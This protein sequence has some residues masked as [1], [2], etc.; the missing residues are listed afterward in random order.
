MSR[1][2]LI[3]AM[4]K[5]KAD[6]V[7]KTI[8]AVKTRCSRV[9]YSDMATG[10][11]RETFTIRGKDLDEIEKELLGALVMEINKQREVYLHCCDCGRAIK[12]SRL[13]IKNYPHRTI[14]WCQR[15]ARNL[16]EEIIEKYAEDTK[17]LSK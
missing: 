8:A 15:C 9:A 10:K 2:R 13:L 5:V 17:C 1:D 7:H 11:M 12:K 14:M 16:A 6:T 4:A 3:E